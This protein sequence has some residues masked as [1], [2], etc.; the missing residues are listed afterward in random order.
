MDP[1]I[2]HLSMQVDVDSMARRRQR[3]KKLVMWLLLTVLL[4]A[5]LLIA[6]ETVYAE[7]ETSVGSGEVVIYRVIH[8]RSAIRK[9]APEK[10][11][12]VQTGSAAKYSD[13][14]SDKDLA[15]IASHNGSSTSTD[16]DAAQ[17]LRNGSFT[18]L[19]P[20]GSH[21]SPMLGSGVL[22]VSGT[23]TTAIGSVNRRIGS[24]VGRTLQPFSHIPAVT[25]SAVR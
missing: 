7:G 5:C 2:P 19:Y 9:S 17:G 15:A 3:L 18:S 4:A 8:T 6:T 21:S 20:S 16:F 1:Y 25:P 13:Q 10:P 12:S 14:V 11:V 24:D 22:S 23:V